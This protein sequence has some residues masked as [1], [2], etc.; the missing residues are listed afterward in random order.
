M[1]F[2]QLIRGAVP[3]TAYTYSGE[4]IACNLCA[5]AESAVLS[6]YDRR[7]KKMRTVICLG[8]GLH[9]TDP[10]PT[11]AELSEYYRVSYR[12][13]YQLAGSKPPKF[14]LKRSARLAQE[15][16]NYLAPAMGKDARV[17][18]VG[19]G[20]A[21]LLKEFQTAGS[22]VTGIEPGETYAE[23]ATQTHGIEV[24]NKNWS[25]IDFAERKFDIIVSFHVFEHLRDPV[26]AL[27][28]MVSC[29]SDDGVIVLEV[30]NMLPTTKWRLFERL[31]F[32]HVHGFVPKTLELLGAVC[33][34]EPDPRL[35]SQGARMAFRVAKNRAGLA[36][37]DPAYAAQLAGQYDKTNVAAHILKGKW[38]VDAFGRLGRDIRDTVK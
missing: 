3:F 32:A 35:R 2:L 27:K 14:H 6:D 34:L 24:L 28:W 20:T 25:D 7:I 10:M 38:I 4:A 15:R 36:V 8:C 5:S 1:A 37:A 19:C 12:L 16:F 33:G 29:L 17:L 26:S 21:E 30:P 18:D 13:D 22:A 23:Y 9:R 31:H 11:D